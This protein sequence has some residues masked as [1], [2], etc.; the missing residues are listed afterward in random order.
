MDL[1][2]QKRFISEALEAHNDYRKA[3]GVQP[4]DLDREL[5]KSALEW[6]ELLAKTQTFR[7]SFKMF[8]S[9]PVGENI[10]KCDLTNTGKIYYSGREATSRWYE[11]ARDYDYDESNFRPDIGNFTQVVY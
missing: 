5:T 11:Q 8:R 3:H 7:Y 10:L 9:E 6:A 1:V 4:L 2:S